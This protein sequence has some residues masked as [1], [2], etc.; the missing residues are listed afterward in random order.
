MLIALQLLVALRGVH[1]CRLVSSS[2]RWA[3]E[4][5]QPQH[6]AST[7]ASSQVRPRSGTCFLLRPIQSSVA[8]SWL[9]ASQAPNSSGPEKNVAGRSALPPGVPICFGFVVPMAA[10]CH[11]PVTVHAKHGDTSLRLA[12][13]RGGA[14]SET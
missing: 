10:A 4:S 12:G 6:S 2:M 14:G 5:I 11:E 7:T 9:A 13:R 3:T 8:V 1:R